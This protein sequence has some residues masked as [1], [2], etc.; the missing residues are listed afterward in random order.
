LNVNRL[1]RHATMSHAGAVSPQAVQVPPPVVVVER[2]LFGVIRRRGPGE[3]ASTGQ[4]RA[5]VDCGTRISGLCANCSIEAMEDDNRPR[6]KE[7]CCEKANLSCHD[8]RHTRL[9]LLLQEAGFT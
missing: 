2:A 4:R 5:G 6:P 3:S 8:A 1:R 9:A 7:R